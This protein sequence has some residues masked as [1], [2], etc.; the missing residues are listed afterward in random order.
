MPLVERLIKVG[1]GLLTLKELQY[2]IDD[3]RGSH[4]SRQTAMVN[5]LLGPLENEWLGREATG[6][7]NCNSH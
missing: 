5:R 7:G 3:H 1:N 4:R 2:G 6:R